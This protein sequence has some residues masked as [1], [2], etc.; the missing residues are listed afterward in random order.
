MLLEGKSA[1]VWG[2]AGGMGGG[3]ARAFAREGATVHLVGR[4]LTTLEKVRDDIV[5]AGGSADIAVLDAFDADQVGAFVDGL[6]RVDVS[7]NALSVDVVQNRPMWTIPVDALV[8]PVAQMARSQFTTGMAVA[9]RMID[10]RSGVIILLSSSAARE[11]GFEMGGFAMACASNECFAR[12]L[13]G[14]IGQYGVRVVALRP[15]FTPET[16][17]GPVDLTDEDGLAPLVR[18]TALRRLPRL[19]EVADTAAFVASD[20]GGAIT[21]AVIN[22]SCG[23]IAD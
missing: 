21:A 3:V 19:A 17:G 20:S 6:D 14:E 10:Q 13:G 23:A 1:I 22:L 5:A 15:N 11:S 12:S 8:A 4:T 16:V 9:K 2:G 18:G 7:F